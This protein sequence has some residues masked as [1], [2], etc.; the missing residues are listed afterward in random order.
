MLKRVLIF[1]FFSSLPIEIF[2]EEYV[3]YG[4]YKDGQQ[5]ITYLR[6]EN[7]FKEDYFVETVSF[8]PPEKVNIIKETEKMLFLSHEPVMTSIFIVIID[9]ENLKFS[10]NYLRLKDKETDGDDGSCTVK[11]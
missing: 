9:K 10:H 3:C 11:N 4:P 8:H 7:F 2:S 1:L 6:E 5:K